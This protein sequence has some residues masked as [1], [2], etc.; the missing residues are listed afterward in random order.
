MTDTI[1]DLHPEVPLN[2]IWGD[3]N[4]PSEERQIYSAWKKV[5]LELCRACPYLEAVKGTAEN[6]RNICGQTG[7]CI[8]GKAQADYRNIKGSA[9]CVIQTEVASLMNKPVTK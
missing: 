6:T 4:I 1:N 5:H 2:A 9:A 7:V 3:Y 8:Y